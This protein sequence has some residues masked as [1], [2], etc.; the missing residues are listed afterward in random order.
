MDHQ[1]IN[2]LETFVKNEGFSQL[3]I[4]RSSTSQ[5]LSGVKDDTRL[6]LHIAVGVAVPTRAE[7]VPNTPTELIV[8]RP[9][10]PGITNAITGL[11][12]VAG[13]AGAVSGHKHDRPQAE[14][15]ATE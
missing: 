13:G 5:T 6:V 3:E 1:L 8:T 12:Q 7:A 2:R 11:P 10:V 9:V 15:T 14:T 4:Q